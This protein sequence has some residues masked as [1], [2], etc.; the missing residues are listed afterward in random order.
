MELFVV[1]VSGGYRLPR[2]E[3]LMTDFLL[4]KPAAP[5]LLPRDERGFAGRSVELSELD[6][7]GD[8]GLA[9]LAGAGGGGKT[10]LAVRWG[11]RAA[12][13]FPDGQ[14]FVNLRGFDHVAQP[15]EPA[16]ALRRFLTA[17]GVPTRHIPAGLGGR[18]A[19]YRAE[20]ADR[21][22]L[23]VL[24]NAGVATQVRP[25]L[26]AASGC[27]TV[28]TTRN[29]LTGLIVREG[30]KLTAVP[31]LSTADAA[32]LLINRLGWDR[33]ATDALAVA[34]VIDRCA[35]MP[36]ALSLITARAGGRSLAAVNAEIGPADAAGDPHTSVRAVFAWSFGRLTAPAARLFRLIGHHPGPDLTATAAAGLTGLTVG[37][38]TVVLAELARAALLTEAAPGRYA[39]HDLLRAYAAERV[40]RSAR[41]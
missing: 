5:A 3:A 23:V 20:M 28:V 22:A 6:T 35:R 37:Q 4:L 31:P 30:A 8:G 34:A 11:H 2:P 19:L 25:L 27:V 21:R 15:M 40:S 26:P 32:Q 41:P 33:V 10:A 12:G 17:L 36:L 39:C 24:D 7:I 1:D 9:M 16:E 14:L 38:A 13:R 29:Q 18:V